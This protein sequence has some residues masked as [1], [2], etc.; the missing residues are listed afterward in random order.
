MRARFYVTWLIGTNG[1]YAVFVSCTDTAMCRLPGGT[2]FL[3]AEMPA[4]NL[5]IVET[6]KNTALGWKKQAKSELETLETDRGTNPIPHPKERQRTGEAV[7]NRHTGNSVA[8]TRN[9]HKA[10]GQ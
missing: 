1:I 6:D 2:T 9:R 8:K 4:T 3:L 7:S 5:G 10:K